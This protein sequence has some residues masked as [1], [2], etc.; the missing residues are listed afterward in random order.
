MCL[1][2]R[3]LLLKRLLLVRS[4]EKVSMSLGGRRIDAREGRKEMLRVIEGMRQ[5]GERR[6]SR[7]ASPYP[8]GGGK[9]RGSH[10]PPRVDSPITK[11]PVR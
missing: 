11:S 9:K 6:R 5:E 2:M 3:H 4:D 7:S 8:S 10:D 1:N